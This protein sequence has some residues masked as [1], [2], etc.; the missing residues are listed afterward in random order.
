MSSKKRG[1]NTL[2]CEVLSITP[3]GLWLLVED[4]EYFLKHKDFPWFRTAP[5]EAVLKVK[6]LS[7]DHLYWPLLDVDLHLGSIKQPQAYPLISRSSSNSKSK[8]AK[9]R[10][11]VRAEQ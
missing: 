7:S 4:N 9:R 6:R 11:K 8:V 1:K 2:A 3:F 10:T 5:L